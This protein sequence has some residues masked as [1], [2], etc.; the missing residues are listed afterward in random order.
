MNKIY[1]VYCYASWAE[2][3]ITSLYVRAR[4]EKEAY[5]IAL[6]Y[7]KQYNKKE[8]FEYYTEYLTRSGRVDPTGGTIYDGPKRPQIYELKTIN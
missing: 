1:I 8:G 5:T 4:T 7:M 3:T 6:E 2:T